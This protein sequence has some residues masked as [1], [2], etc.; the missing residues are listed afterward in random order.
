ML[1]YELPIT[2][3]ASN[4]IDSVP[5]CELT[6]LAP[7]GAKTCCTADV[8]HPSWMAL[9]SRGTSTTS[10]GF[11]IVRCIRGHIRHLRLDS[12]NAGDA[13]FPSRT[14]FLKLCNA[15][16]TSLSPSY[17]SRFQ[18]LVQR[19]RCSVRIVDCLCHVRC[20]ITA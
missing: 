16:W 17:S 7:T 2:L 3:Q 19:V 20:P 15:N 11:N 10:C 12:S 18:W 1:R 9:L 8:S 4:C 13:L 5:S 6:F 14:V